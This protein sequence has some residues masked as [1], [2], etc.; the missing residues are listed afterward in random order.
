[1]KY[2]VIFIILFSTTKCLSQSD[3]AILTNKNAME[4]LPKNSTI[5][6]LSETELKIVMELTESSISKYNQEVSE[7]FTKNGEGK[8]VKSH[9]I[10]KLKNYRV[11]YIPYI[12]ESGEKEVW[13]NGFCSDFGAENWK[14]EVVFVFDGGN[15]YFEIRLNLKEK[16][17]I[18]IGINGYA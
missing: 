11:Q 8:Y 16:S 9:K 7:S 4:F 13:I 1:M 17:C 12:N 14:N 2:I 3:F 18:E 5:S 10:K 6:T 15:C